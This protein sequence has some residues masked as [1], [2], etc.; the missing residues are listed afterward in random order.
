MDRMY[1]DVHTPNMTNF[2]SVHLNPVNIQ[3]IGHSTLNMKHF[4][5][6]GGSPC[7]TYQI[8]LTLKGLDNVLVKIKIL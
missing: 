5:E 1:I 7:R 6:N 3:L 8:C 2:G 4:Q